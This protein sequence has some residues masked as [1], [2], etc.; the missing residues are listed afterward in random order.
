MRRSFSRTCACCAAKMASVRRRNSSSLRCF[1]TSAALRTR[2]SSSSRRLIAR[3]SSALASKRSSASRRFAF[4]SA[5]ASSFC[6]WIRSNTASLC[7]L[8][9]WAFSASRAASTRRACATFASFLA[10]RR[11]AVRFASCITSSW[12]AVRRRAAS[13]RRSSSRTADTDSRPEMGASAGWWLSI[14]P[15]A[16]AGRDA[17][18]FAPAGDRSRGPPPRLERGCVRDGEA[19]AGEETDPASLVAPT[20]PGTLAASSTAGIASRAALSASTRSRRTRSWRSHLKR[21]CSALSPGSAK[22]ETRFG[23][24]IAGSTPCSRQARTERGE[25]SAGG[26]VS[27]GSRF[28]TSSMETRPRLSLPTEART[29][30]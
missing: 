28:A 25:V 13:S 27:R 29:H 4:S 18:E 23:A 6:R 10:R 7:F 16:V 14:R 20:T 8:S 1:S 2:R 5:F 3:R 24:S 26:V 11:S 17:F 9:T 21:W 15:R 30:A 22:S 19:G 12:R